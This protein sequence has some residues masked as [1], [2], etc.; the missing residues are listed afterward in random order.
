MGL[1]MILTLMRQ[2]SWQSTTLGTLFI[3]GVREC[4][5]LEDQVRH[6][7]KIPG[8][9]AIPAGRYQVV[10]VHSPRFGCDMPRLVGVPGFDGILIHSGNSAA[11]TRGCL[12]VGDRVVNAQTIADSRVAYERLADKIAKAQPDCWIEVVDATPAAGDAV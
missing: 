3:D 11:D 6:A 10:V 1:A 2:P 7:A 12:L 5:T 9:T 4:D 8:Q